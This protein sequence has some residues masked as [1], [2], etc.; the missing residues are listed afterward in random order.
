MLDKNEVK[1]MVQEAVSNKIGEQVLTEGLKKVTQIDD[2][3][4]YAVVY[5]DAEYDEFRVKFYKAGKYI[6]DKADYHTD[7]KADAVGTAKAELKRMK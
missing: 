6:G 4:N 2:G 3:D 1:R 5:R 7:D